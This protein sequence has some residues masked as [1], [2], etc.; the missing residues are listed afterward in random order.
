MTAH[1]WVQNGESLVTL[2]GESGVLC[3]WNFKHGVPEFNRDE[4]RKLS[5][6]FRRMVAARIQKPGQSPGMPISIVPELP[7]Y[8]G[9][10]Y[11]TCLNQ[12]LK[13]AQQT[14]TSKEWPFRLVGIWTVPH[15]ILD[16]KDNMASITINALEYFYRQN[17]KCGVC[18]LPSGEIKL[19]FCNSKRN[20]Y[21]ILRIRCKDIAMLSSQFASTEWVKE[22]TECPVVDHVPLQ[23]GWENVPAKYLQFHGS[24]NYICAETVRTFLFFDVETGKFLVDLKHSDIAREWLTLRN[25]DADKNDIGLHL[26]LDGNLAYIEALVL[27]RRARSFKGLRRFLFF[28]PMD[29][30]RAH[31]KGLFFEFFHFMEVKGRDRL[32]Q[33]LDSKICAES[34][35]AFAMKA[36][37]DKAL[38]MKPTTLKRHDDEDNQ[39]NTGSKR[40]RIARNS[41]AQSNL[42]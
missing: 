16:P 37:M 17:L 19:L 8:F 27:G 7:S 4:K 38:T 36:A 20:S 25:V 3:F 9:A 28:L 12:W 29:M 15:E 10:E 6:Q 34:Y 14:P 42:K 13:D 23:Y 22:R 1:T 30:I 41:T 39:V 35:R 18:S 2:H 40:R 21:E 24:S 5:K 32:Q 11:L 26:W 31:N 33:V